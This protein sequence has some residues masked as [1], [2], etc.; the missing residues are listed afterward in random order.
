MLNESS[1]L[2]YKEA[3]LNA[4]FVTGDNG[5]QVGQAIPLADVVKGNPLISVTFLTCA[6]DDCSTGTPTPLTLQTSSWQSASFSAQVVKLLELIQL[7]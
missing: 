4:L 1:F 2:G 7:N 5:Y 6:S 3:G